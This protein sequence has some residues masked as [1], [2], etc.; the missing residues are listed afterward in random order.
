MD[1]NKYI[2]LNTDFSGEYSIEYENLKYNFITDFICNQIGNKNCFLFEMMP[3]KHSI[4]YDITS[5]HKEAKINAKKCLYTSNINLKKEDI[6][7]IIKE[8]EFYLGHLLIIISEIKE[9]DLIDIA[10]LWSNGIYKTGLEIFKMDSDGLS[11][12]WYNPKSDLAE[13]DFES[14]V[15]NFEISAASFK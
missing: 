1:F 3:T 14:F 5:S 11:F 4:I 15:N 2:I 8:E 12:Y 10:N 7:N 6:Y 9:K 13:N